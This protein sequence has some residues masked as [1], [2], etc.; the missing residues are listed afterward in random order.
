MAVEISS[1]AGTL[2]DP[3]DVDARSLDAPFLAGPIAGASRIG[4][5]H[6]REGGP[7]EDGFAMAVHEG[8]YPWFALAVADGVGSHE[9]AHVGANAAVNAS[10]EALAERDPLDVHRHPASLVSLA[11]SRGLARLEAEAEEREV[12]GRKLSCT[13]LLLVAVPREEGYRVATFQAGDGGIYAVSWD[14]DFHEVGYGREAELGGAVY[15]L[16]HPETTRTWERRKHLFTLEPPPDAF[17]VMTDGVAD[18]LYPPDRGIPNILEYLQKAPGAAEPHATI[19]EVISYEKPGS[20]DDRTL[21]LAP[22]VPPG[23][24]R[25][26]RAPLTERA[27]RVLPY[28]TRREDVEEP[29]EEPEEDRS[30]DGSLGELTFRIR[31]DAEAPDTIRDPG[32]GTR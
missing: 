6:A 5:A 16:N 17:L 3:V 27:R 28:G 10:V 15:Q 13:L 31:G 25:S 12:P 26:K 24:E 29:E 14:G 1:P 21:G 4:D 7:R 9:M 19:R 18:D 20:I 8:S 30:E 23:R 32:G 11:A 2:E 22:V